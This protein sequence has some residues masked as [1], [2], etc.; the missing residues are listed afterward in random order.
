[1]GLLSRI[2]GKQH[3][4]TTAWNEQAV[5]IHFQ[6]GLD[7]L[8]PLYDLEAKLKDLIEKEDKG[9]FDGH[10]IALDLSDGFLYM[11]G[12]NAES[13]YKAVRPLLQQ[14]TFMKGATALLRFGLP[15]D[16][17]QEIRVAVND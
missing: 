1:M 5:I 2:F 14:I 12:A 3:T 16:G 7:G 4:K 13:L 8:Q 9:V 11:Y 6:Y 15:E 10:E 17:V